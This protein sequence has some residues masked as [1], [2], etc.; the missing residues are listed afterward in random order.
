M[1]VRDILHLAATRLANAGCDTPRLDA[2]LLLMHVWHASR[3]ELFTRAYEPLAS[4][5]QDTFEQLISRRARRE[6]LAYITGEREFWSRPFRVTPDVLIPRPETEH[7]IEAV[8]SRFPDRHGHYRFCDIGTGSGCIA[9]TL[10]AEYPHASV[11]ATDISASALNVARDNAERLGTAA[12]MSFRC[13]DML[14]ALHRGE[15]GPFDAILSNPPYVTAAEMDGLEPEL[16]AEPRHALTDEHDG[17]TFL[18]TIVNEAPAWLTETGYIMVETGPC[19]LPSL[20]P[21]LTLDEEV[22]DLAGHLRGAV[23]QRN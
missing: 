19:G 23:Y 6:P 7:M 21:V 20:P 10:A 4:D 13:A 17:L 2:E 1:T 5:I 22:R 18:T 16:D 15:D 12:R 3:T 9:I 14:M 8:L 11:V